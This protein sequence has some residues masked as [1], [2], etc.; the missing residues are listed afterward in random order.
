M[1]SNGIST[2]LGKIAAMIG[3]QSDGTGAVSD[4]GLMSIFRKLGIHRVQK[5]Y[6]GMLLEYGY[7]VWDS[8]AKLY[9]L[10][11]EG[12]TSCTITIIVTPCLNAEEVHG[13]LVD[14]FA[15]YS[16]VIKIG[17]DV[18]NAQDTHVQEFCE[19]VVE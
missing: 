8:E 3:D 13:H 11:A 17:E 12:K 4:A 14:A 2:N 15:A 10:T 16:P 19:E 18:K 7:L 5:Y 9:R 1:K 6:T